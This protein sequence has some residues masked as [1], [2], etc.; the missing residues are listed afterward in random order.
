MCHQISTL[1]MRVR[2]GYYNTPSN[3]DVQESEKRFFKI[4]SQSLYGL[5]TIEK[6]QTSPFNLVGEEK[7]AE[8]IQAAY[9]DIC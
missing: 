6:L 9:R 2:T 1:N 4:G 8:A 3:G 5:N 7:V